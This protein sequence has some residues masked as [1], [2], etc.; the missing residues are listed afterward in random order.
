M[1]P[2]PTKSP[3]TSEPSVSLVPSAL[4]SYS[5]SPSLSPSAEKCSDVRVQIK[6]QTDLFPLQTYWTL[7]NNCGT[8]VAHSEKYE[9]A[10]KK[11]ATKNF[12]LP[13][14]KYNF[15][16]YDSNGDGLKCQGWCWGTGGYYEILVEGIMTIKY[17]GYWNTEHTSSFG[18]ATSC[19]GAPTASEPVTIPD[20]LVPNGCD[21]THACDDNPLTPGQRCCAMNDAEVSE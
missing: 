5:V 2:Q 21:A 17:D 3:M 15:T 13:S 11:Y 1:P 20:Y 14:D 18:E 9:Q 10:G 12:C 8:V 7:T 4:P 6:V 19:I 16:I